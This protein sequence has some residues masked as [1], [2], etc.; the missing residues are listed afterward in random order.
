MIDRNLCGRSRSPSLA[1]VRLADRCSEQ[2]QFFFGQRGPSSPLHPDTWRYFFFIAHVHHLC[3][4]DSPFPRRR[5]HHYRYTSVIFFFDRKAS[6]LGNSAAPIPE[7]LFF[8]RRRHEQGPDNGQGHHHY[9]HRQLQLQ[10][11]QHRRR[12]Q[13][14]GRDDRGK[15]CR[16]DKRTACERNCDV[17]AIESRLCGDRRRQKTRSISG[18]GGG[19]QIG[20]S[21]RELRPLKTV[22]VGTSRPAW[23]GIDLGGFRSGRGGEG[24]R[25][26]DRFRDRSWP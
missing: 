3:G 4:G 25:G 5:R 12:R 17:N 11:H 19:G 7:S 14:R 1:H 26:S 20:A 21:D 2:L 15:A 23:R 6:G 8:W 22:V 10:R 13:G 18:G 24:E 9:H 16:A